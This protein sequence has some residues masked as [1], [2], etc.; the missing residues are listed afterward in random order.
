MRLRR[1]SFDPV[2]E[3]IHAL[4]SGGLAVGGK[5]TRR[6]SIWSKIGASRRLAKRH[7][8]GH[9]RHTVCLSLAKYDTGKLLWQC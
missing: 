6:R 8:H 5:G 7:E 2:T 9:S 4:G 3:P 1:L